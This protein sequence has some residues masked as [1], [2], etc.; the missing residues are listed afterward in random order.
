MCIVRKLRWRRGIKT[1]RGDVE[2]VESEIMSYSREYGKEK[3]VYRK[4]KDQW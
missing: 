2:I 1:L 3:G 4:D